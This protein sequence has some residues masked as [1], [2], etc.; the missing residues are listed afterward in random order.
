MNATPINT[1]KTACARDPLTEPACPACATARAVGARYCPQ[2]GAALASRSPDP[3]PAPATV[4]VDVEPALVDVD[5]DGV[6]HLAGDGP[7]SAPIAGPLPERQPDAP[8]EPNSCPYC[9]RAVDAEHGPTFRLVGVGDDQLS[10][11]LGDEPLII[12]KDDTCGLVIGDDVY[13]SRR[14]ARVS[15][16]GDLF[17]LEDLGS[18]NGTLLKIRRPIL[19]EPG[20]EIIVG[21]TVLRLDVSAQS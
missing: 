13:V 11:T 3:E 5:D 18:S 8:A 10:V 19:I 7:A 12:G 6:T 9:G 20:D 15:R 1:A 16:D 14:H 21:G 17:Y 4:P 2:C